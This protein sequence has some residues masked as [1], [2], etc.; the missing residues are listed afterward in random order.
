M[1]I[2]RVV[3]ITLADLLSK[4]LQLH[5]EMVSSE[6]DSEKIRKV[7]S[8]A[9]KSREALQSLKTNMEQEKSF[10]WGSGT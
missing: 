1:N 5:L 4:S 6:T 10:I 2:N 7:L 3:V 9:E 8:I